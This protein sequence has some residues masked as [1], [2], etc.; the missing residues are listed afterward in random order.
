MLR[1]FSNIDYWQ[2]HVQLKEV[3]RI[4]S[5]VQRW[6]LGS[7]HI[8]ILST[9]NVN[10]YAIL[11]IVIVEGTYKVRGLPAQEPHGGHSLSCCVDVR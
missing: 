11:L 3:S 6:Y 10:K 8:F 9:H 4:S 1:R 7:N 5:V 2:R